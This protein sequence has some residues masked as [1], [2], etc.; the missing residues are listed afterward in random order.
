MVASDRLR[1]VVLRVLDTVDVVSEAV[2]VV[3]VSVTE[4][5]VLDTVLLWDV[6]LVVCVEVLVAV[7]E[8]PVVVTLELVRL[9]AVLEVVVGG[10]QTTEAL[11]SQSGVS[12]VLQPRARV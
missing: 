7:S 1:L 9:V 5:R 3:A 6:E 4:L 12:R 10:R 2:T 11:P 8:V